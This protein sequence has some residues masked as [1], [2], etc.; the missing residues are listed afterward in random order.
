M[1]ETTTV[2]ATTDPAEATGDGGSYLS[3][4]LWS[5]LTTVDHKRIGVMYG[6]SALFF[7][8]LGGVEALIIRLQLAQPEAGLISADLYNQLFT[9]HGTTMI[10]L[11]LMPLIAAFF[12]FV[13]PLQI[14]AR[15]VAFPRL[16]AFSFWTFLFGALFLNASFFFGGAPDAGWFGYAN[17]TSTQFSPGMRIDFWVLG[18]Q[19]LGVSSLVSALNFAVTILNLR[20]PGLKLMRMPLFSWMTLVTSFLMIMAFPAITV[21]MTLLMFDRFFD[22]NFYSVAAGGTPILWQHLFWIFG[23]PE[24]YILILPTMGIISDVLPTFSEKPLFGYPVVVY[25]GVL[26]AFIGFGVWAHHMFSAGLGP[27]ANSVFAIT[28]MIIA[29][30]TGVKIF[31]WIATMWGG[32]LRFTTPMLFAVGFIALFIIGGL[33]GVMHSSPPADLQQ[34]DSYFV[35]AHI[36][37]VLFGGTLMGLFAG[38]YYWFPKVTGRTLDETLGKWHFWTTFVTMNLTFFPMHFLGLHGMPRRTFT[39]EEGLGFAD[40][41]L[42]ATV[43]AFLLAGSVAIFVWNVI[44]SV[45]SGEAAEANPWGAATL[46]W[47][48]PS[49]PPHYNFAEIPTVRGRDP[50]WRDGGADVVAVG[51]EPAMPTPSWRPILVSAGILLTAVGALAGL[52]IVGLGTL[53]IV[54][55]V[56]SWAYE[57]VH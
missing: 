2:A 20:A 3:G 26:I 18:L 32:K 28:T 27:V 36:H 9:M 31:N 46:E 35:V 8:L 33:S 41:N 5:W 6:V 45:R 34:T 47:A 44:R 16:N 50:L 29:V 57:P 49:P 21:G 1:S 48:I 39:Y 23:H 42:A 56:F 4:G 12:N 24:V 25:S 19:I 10:F 14:G 15:D 11:A 7:F 40:M 22:A 55:G 43:G 54:Y 17:L 37:Y 13:V 53:V 38:I 51:E 52:W 30:P